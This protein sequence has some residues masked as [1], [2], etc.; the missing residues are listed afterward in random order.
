MPRRDEETEDLDRRLEAII[1]Y[2]VP[3]RLFSRA[4]DGG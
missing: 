2:N 4:T 1:N 3:Q